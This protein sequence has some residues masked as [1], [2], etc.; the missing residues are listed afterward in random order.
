M[1]LIDGQRSDQINALDR[2]LA[3]GDGVFRTLRAV[4]GDI[5]YWRRHYRKLA[6][7]CAALSLECPVQSLLRAEL[8][9]L[10]MAEP[11]CVVKII[12]TRGVGG[13]GFAFPSSARCTRVVASFPSPV[14]RAK[15]DV[16]GVRVRWCETRL[17]I[18]PRLA[19]IKH[20]NRLENV[21]A[22]SEWNDA[23]IVEGLMLDRE[24]RVVEGTYCN[25]FL[26]EQGRLI[27]PELCNCGVAGVQRERV[28]EV[29][30]QAGIPCSVEI[31]SQARVCNADQVLICNSV[32][33]LWWVSALEQRRWRRCDET[34]VL[35]RG[36]EALRD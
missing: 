34:T 24:G 36:L 18:Q 11:E 15:V 25:L 19:G 27:T 9:Q 6:S 28:M 12:V 20:L 1:I 22:R 35:T 26:V 7:D 30:A 31:V 33:G 23:D 17:A 13:R 2:G 8:A 4:R 5:P 21:L 10:L 16:L 32:I 3:Y 14:T 29:A